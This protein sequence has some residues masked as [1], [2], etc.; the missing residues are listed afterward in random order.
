[1]DRRKTVVQSDKDWEV[2]TLCSDG[3]CI[4]VIGADGRCKVCGLPYEGA[5]PLHA[6]DADEETVDELPEAPGDAEASENE[7]NLPESPVAE[8]EWEDRT[9]CI[10][11]GCIGVVGSDGRCKE[12]GKPHPGKAS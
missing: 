3:N 4:G 10:D 7:D 11:E 9:L 1:M 2:R 12:C 5:L 6:A 8:D